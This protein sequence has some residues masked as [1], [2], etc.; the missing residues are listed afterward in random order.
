MV[1]NLMFINLSS[2]T[3]R[4]RNVAKKIFLVIFLKFQISRREKKGQNF[5]FTSLMNIPI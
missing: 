2:V 4:I 5:E 3:R 1:T